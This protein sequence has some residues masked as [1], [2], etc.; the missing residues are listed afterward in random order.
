MTNKEVKRDTETSMWCT[1]T[2]IKTDMRMTWSGYQVDD[3]N[4]STKIDDSVS[5]SRSNVLTLK[6][7]A[8]STDSKLTCTVQSVESLVSEIKTFDVQLLVYSECQ[9][10]S[11]YRF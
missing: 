3:V 4:Y 10:H 8:V 11:L 6:S 5:G 9:M 2:D 1:I 7:G